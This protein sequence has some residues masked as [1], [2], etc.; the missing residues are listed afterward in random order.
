MN[1]HDQIVLAFNTYLKE[2]GNFEKNEVKISATRARI[3]LLELSKLIP[4]RRKE[5][6]T[7]KK[8]IKGRAR[9]D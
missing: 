8:E 1:T 7:D 9:I 3:A 2:M 5:L 4:P 6:L